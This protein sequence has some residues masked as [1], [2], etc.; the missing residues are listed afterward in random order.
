MDRKARTFFSAS[1]EEAETLTSESEIKRIPTFV[2]NIASFEFFRSF[3][4]F[5]NLF[6]N[7]SQINHGLHAVRVEI[8]TMRLLGSQQV[9]GKKDEIILN[10]SSTFGSRRKISRSNCFCSLTQAAYFG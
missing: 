4:Q 10:T 9:F 3:C 6:R 8:S 2:D 7:V 5:L 1:R